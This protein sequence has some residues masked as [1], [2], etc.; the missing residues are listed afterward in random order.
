MKRIKPT[1][2][3]DKTGIGKVPKSSIHIENVPHPRPE[4]GRSRKTQRA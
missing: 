2:P 3:S 1:L 4:V